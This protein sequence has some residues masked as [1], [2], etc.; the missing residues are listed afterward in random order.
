MQYI[1][2]LC[3][4]SIE[5]FKHSYSDLNFLSHALFFLYIITHALFMEMD[6]NPHIDKDSWPFITCIRLCKW[7]RPPTPQAGCQAYPWGSTRNVIDSSHRQVTVTI[8]H[9]ET[10]DVLNLR[11]SY[12]FFLRWQKPHN[13]LRFNTPLTSLGRIQIIELVYSNM[14]HCVGVTDFVWLFECLQ[15]IKWKCVLCN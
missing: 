14:M 13:S 6:V 5:C 12:V 4:F 2:H 9:K 7:L 10:L 8:C 3:S 11:G 1:S 15:K